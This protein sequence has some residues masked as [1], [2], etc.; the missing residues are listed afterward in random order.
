MFQHF[1]HGFS[2]S[3][4]FLKEN[5]QKKSKCMSEVPVS[6]VPLLPFPTRLLMLLSEDRGNF[7]LQSPHNSFT[8]SCINYTFSVLENCIDIAEHK[9]NI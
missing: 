5:K 8:P 2:L 1:K 7:V 9:L 6:A 3:T 4:V